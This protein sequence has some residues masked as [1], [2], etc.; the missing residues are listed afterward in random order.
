MARLERIVFGITNSAARFGFVP[1][2]QVAQPAA[3]WT[4]VLDFDPNWIGNSQNAV[5][6]SGYLVS[7]NVPIVPWLPPDLK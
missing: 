5:K 7:A 3:R 4:L 2:A 1:E 6:V